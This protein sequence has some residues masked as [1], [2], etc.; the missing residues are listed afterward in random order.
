M[1]QRHQCDPPDPK[2]SEADLPWADLPDAALIARLRTPATSLP[3]DQ[4]PGDPRARRK[5]IAAAAAELRRRRLP[6]LLDYAALFASAASVRALALEALQRAVLDIRTAPEADRSPPHQP[7]LLVECTAGLWAGTARRQE[8][9]ADFLAWVD[10]T[11]HAFPCVPSDEPSSV[12]AGLICWA[13]H[14]LPRHAQATVWHTVVQRDDARTAGRSLGTAP[15]RVPHLRRTALEDL[16][17]AC[18]ELHAEWSDNGHCRPFSSLLE[19]A[20]R[21][22]GPYPSGDLDRHMAVCHDCCRAH[23]DLTG[24]NEQPGT[25]LATALLPWG[26]AAFAAARRRR[27]SN[28]PSVAKSERRPGTAGHALPRTET[29]PGLSWLRHIA[30]RSP[31]VSVTAAAGILAVAATALQL[32]VTGHH[33]GAA[34]PVPAGPTRTAGDP[35]AAPPPSPGASPDRADR[36]K[37]ASRSSGG[38]DHAGAEG[39]VHDQASAHPGRPPYAPVVQ[40]PSVPPSCNSEQK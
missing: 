29:A 20:T 26:G 24:V 11:T 19:A 27:T 1:P 23:S 30:R 25:V 9:S 18:L 12:H 7:L 10:R 36:T 14:R 3:D 37:H 35:T 13:Y 40:S 38:K 15:D 34:G 31:A 28:A 2:G 5:Q 17:Q 8:L 32:H 22:N 21:R 4:S 16:R 39:H 33:T 6:A